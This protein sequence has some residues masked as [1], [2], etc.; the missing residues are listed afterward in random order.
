MKQLPG[1]KGKKMNLDTRDKL[2]EITNLKYKDVVWKYRF[3][4]TVMKILQE[5]MWKASGV[6]T[7]YIPI[8]LYF[9]VS[10]S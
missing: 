10:I 3:R 1:A 7:T 5:M 6:K 4:N 8:S 9:L 2:Y